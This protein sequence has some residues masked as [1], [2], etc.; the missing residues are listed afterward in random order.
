MLRYAKERAK[1]IGRGSSRIAFEI[2]YEGRKTVLKIAMN[3][4]GLVQNEEEANLLSDY[5]VRSLDITIPIID[6]DESS[7]HRVSW[8]HTEFAEKMKS[9]KA[10]EKFFGG[11]SIY[12]IT[13][14]LNNRTG[15]LPEWIHENEYFSS[16]QNLIIN[17][18]LPANEYTTASNWGLY[19]G[20]PV[21]IDLGFTRR[22]KELYFPPKPLYNRYL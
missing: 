8:V 12:D 2:P 16:L 1:S 15:E 19:K 13:N 18:N 4:K 5:Y 9:I 22:T 21:I 7:E 10:L 14:Y 6:Y 11:V 20:K 17:Y 3:G